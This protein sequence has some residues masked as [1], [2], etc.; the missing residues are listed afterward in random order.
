MPKV[1]II[2]E[3]SKAAGLIGQFLQKKGMETDIAPDGV[4]ALRLFAGG[5]YDLLLVDIQLPQMN[6]ED[7]CKK[8][9]ATEKGKSLPLIMMSMSARD[10]SDIDRLKKDLDLRGFLTKPFTAEALSSLVSA[11]LQ[12]R[13][14]GS[15]TTSSQQPVNKEPSSLQGNLEKSPFE[16]ILLQF[17]VKRVNGILTLTRESAKRKI[18]FLSG[19]PVELELSSESES[20]GAYLLQKKL[21]DTVELR[22]Y[23]ERRNKR[24]EDSRDIFVKMGCLTPQQ[25]LEENRNFLHDRLIECFSW[26][27]GSFVIEWTP[28]F[29]KTFPAA[30]ILTPSLFYKGFK[31]HLSPARISAFMQEKGNLY[32]DKTAGFFE[33]QNQLAPEAAGAELL[34]RIDGLKTCFE[35]MDSLDP[36]DA[37]A[38]LYTLDHLRLLSYSATPKKSG[39][40]PPFPVRE[41]SPKLLTG[42]AE[43]FE[44]LGGELGELADELGP[45]GARKGV[46]ATAAEAEGLGVLEE[47]LRKQWEA[48]KDKNYYEIFGMQANAFSFDKLKKSYFHLTKTYG[49]E[50]FFASSSE[51]MNLAEEFLSKISNAYETLTNV[52]TKENYDELLASQEQAPTGEEDKEFYEQIQFQSGKVFIE[53]GQYDS[54][55]KAFTNCM[56]INSQ[57]SDYYAYLAFALYNN[58]ANKGNTAAVKR[59]KEL[60]NKSLQLGRLSIAHALKGT[61][62]LDEG[63]LNF[64]E[65]EFSKALKLNPNNK[66]ALKNMEIIR[67]KREKEKKG[68]FGRMFK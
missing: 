11:A 24:G 20:F 36:D 64:A 30:G 53:Q 43:K 59:A 8:I 15:E 46:Q 23:N 21:I 25:F 4:S 16:K 51:V 60:V 47:D 34:E 29:I 67:E 26:R 31:A 33:Y 42:E 28:A 41:K 40:S 9:R 50:K 17:M 65:A 27:T 3:A 1:L 54:A 7:L 45:F 35:I 68:L 57:K 32:P 58:P 10:P 18:F 62:L 38:L 56:T 66:T 13:A 14:G 39:I 44:D 52:V 63:G 6:G 37:A 22:E 12:V 5:A 49:P 61:I 48:S 55:E 19:A 2:E